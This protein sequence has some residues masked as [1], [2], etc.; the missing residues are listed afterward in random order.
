M[1][2]IIVIINSVRIIHFTI[3]HRGLS[4]ASLSPPLPCLIL[5]VIC[6]FVR[7]P[8]PVILFEKDLGIA[9]C[10]SLVTGK[11]Y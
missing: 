3:F 11:D 4:K 7:I 6:L 8:I 1:T 9:T 5:R 10:G 2:N